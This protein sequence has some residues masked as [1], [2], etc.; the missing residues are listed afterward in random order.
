MKFTE[1]LQNKSAITGHVARANHVIEWE[2]MKVI[3][4][5]NDCRTRW[6]KELGHSE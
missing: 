5:E 3:G 6:I 4:H 2:G 1:E